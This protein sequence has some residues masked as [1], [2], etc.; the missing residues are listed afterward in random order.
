MMEK[1][2]PPAPRSFLDAVQSLCKAIL[3]LQASLNTLHTSPATS[4]S[5]RTQHHVPTNHAVIQQTCASFKLQIEQ[6]FQHST[7]IS[8][9]SAL[10]LHSRGTFPL[11]PI[12][13]SY[14]AS[15]KHL[16]APNSSH[17]QI[18]WDVQTETTYSLS[19]LPSGVSLPSNK[20]H[21]HHISYEVSTGSHVLQLLRV[22]VWVGARL[23]IVL[24]QTLAQEGRV[25]FT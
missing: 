2:S 15:R 11:S 18:R 8:M 17:S 21:S 4:L 22:W 25:K 20:H 24:V 3:C 9:L 6:N 16:V 14:S 10:H 7:C 1:I 23:Y 19:S 5:A 12:L 13:T